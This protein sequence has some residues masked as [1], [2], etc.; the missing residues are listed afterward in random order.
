MYS[1]FEVLSNIVCMQEARKLQID[2]PVQFTENVRKIHP[3][4][5]EWTLLPHRFTCYNLRGEIL[6]EWSMALYP[7][8]TSFGPFRKI[9]D[10]RV[11]LAD[12]GWISRTSDYRPIETLSIDCLAEISKHLNPTDLMNMRTTNKLLLNA[13]SSNSVWQPVL[14]IIHDNNKGYR[15]YTDC[16]PFEQCAQY[17][18]HNINIETL[19]NIFMNDEHLTDIFAKILGKSVY[20]GMKRKRDEPLFTVVTRG[21]SR[22]RAHFAIGDPRQAD[23]S[24]HAIIWTTIRGNLRYRTGKIHGTHDDSYILDYV[25]IYLRRLLR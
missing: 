5:T 11:R 25:G 7:I 6:M 2:N 20:R 15:L 18:M 12:Y 22:T 8:A 17:L 14:N 16:S 10:Q 3:N 1:P 4:I 23:G 24:V 21:N 19:K 9:T 13:F